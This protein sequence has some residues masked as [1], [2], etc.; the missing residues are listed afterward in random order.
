VIDAWYSEFLTIGLLFYAE[1][2]QGSSSSVFW[3]IFGVVLSMQYSG[4]SIT[5]QCYQVSIIWHRSKIY[6]AGSVE[7]IYVPIIIQS[8]WERYP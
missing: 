7:N 5:K 6:T 2:Y 4:N 3:L 8:T 1:Y